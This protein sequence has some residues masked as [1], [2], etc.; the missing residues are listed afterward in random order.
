M[1]RDNSDH[2][3]LEATM[4]RGVWATEEREG[5]RRNSERSRRGL[6]PSRAKWYENKH[7]FETRSGI[8]KEYFANGKN[9]CGKRR[10]G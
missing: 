4:M 1:M 9:I 7:D 10:D 5:E 8:I 3:T 2:S 6:K